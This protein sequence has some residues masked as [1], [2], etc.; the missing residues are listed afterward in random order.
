MPEIAP[1]GELVA[2]ALRDAGTGPIFTLNGGHIWGLYLGA[3][4]LDLPMVDVRHE[5]TAG[6]AAEGWARVT[7][8][9]GLAAVTARPGVTNAVSAMATARQND[10]PVLFLGGRAPVARWGMGSLQELDHLPVVRPLTKSAATVP[11]AG[12]SYQMTAEAVR[13]ALR[14]RT[15]PTYLDVPLD[16]FM[17]VG[18]RPTGVERRAP[19]P[20]PEP[21]PN[22]LR[23]VVDL[24]RE[25]RRPALVAGTTVW[26]SH[27][28]Q[29]LVR[30]VEAAGLPAVLNGM[31]R[32]MLPP[33]HRL[34]ASRARG[35]ALGEAD[36]LLVAG[37]PLDFRLNFGQPPLIP[38]ETRLVYL[39]VDDFRK[40]RAAAAA[41]YGDLRATLAELAEAA[42]DVPHRE[43]W[44]E[45]VAQAGS[46]ACSATAASGRSRSTRWSACSALRSSRTWRRAP[47]TTGS[48]RL[49]GATASS[50]NAQRRSVPPWSVPSG[51]VCRRASTF[52]ATRRPSTL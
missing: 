30:L 49:S 14:N 47:A 21:D 41:L 42:R 45:R 33:T 10:S 12:S 29:E 19:D 35:V 50:S 31:A 15:G 48:S 20:G 24:L 1:T 34:F 32:G 2:R 37:A 26:W 28:E 44:I 25:A 13:T 36:L 7:R 22:A 51:R 9:C 6:F 3:R 23:Q 17:A 39:D 18:E 40:H 27:A 46:S 11:D 16:V 4:E 43:E 52:S 5:Q 8:A 38:N